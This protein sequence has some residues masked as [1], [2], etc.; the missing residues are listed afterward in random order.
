MQRQGK[1]KGDGGPSL[2]CGMT[3]KRASNDNGNGKG[4]GKSWLG[5]SVH[6]HPSH[7][8]EGW[9]TRA[10]GANGEEQATAIAT[11]DFSQERCG[12]L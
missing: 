3:S 10:F 9:G 8:R 12:G 6:S 7:K 5:K 1:G 4:K 2:L 11:A